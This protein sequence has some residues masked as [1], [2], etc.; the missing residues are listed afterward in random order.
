[1]NSASVFAGTAGLTAKTVLDVAT[2]GIGVK[3]LSGS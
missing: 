2:S 1:M 3:S